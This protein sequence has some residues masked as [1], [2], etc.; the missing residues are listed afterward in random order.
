MQNRKRA[1]IVIFAVIILVFGIAGSIPCFAGIY[2][3]KNINMDRVNS[4]EI[5]ATF[6]DSMDSVTM[7]LEDSATAITGAADTVSEAKTSLAD[8]SEI[9]KESS[10]ALVEIS[11]LVDF[12]ILGL[13]PMEGVSHYFESIAGDLDSLSVSVGIMAESIG[14]NAGDI[15]KIS[16]DL[17]KISLQLDTFAFSFL[18]TSE[19]IPEFGLK[20]IL[21]FILIY[22]GILNLIFIIIGIALLALSRS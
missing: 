8:A 3:V 9:L 20:N 22:L 1:V 15:K 6:S 10:T 14:G 4:T 21:Y 18:K 17:G 2:F 5:F 12:E 16:E 11:K 7:L 19:S 13:K